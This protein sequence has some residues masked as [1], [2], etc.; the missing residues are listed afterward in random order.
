M[1]KV[2]TETAVRVSLG[3]EVN[4]ML[5]REDMWKRNN[6]GKE[7]SAKKVCIDLNVL[8]LFLENRFVGSFGGIDFVTK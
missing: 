3:E 5:N 4:S 6:F 1:T 2:E 7:V 8:S